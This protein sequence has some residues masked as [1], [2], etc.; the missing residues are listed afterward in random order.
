[1]NR[2]CAQEEQEGEGSSVERKRKRNGALTEAPP[3]HPEAENGEAAGG[4]VGKGTG[5][6]KATTGAGQ[7]KKVRFFFFR[8]V[9][10]KQI[11]CQK[12]AKKVFFVALC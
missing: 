2:H 10:Q 4:I 8:L 9:L 3:P 1:M 6:A 12:S 11:L 7:V 5:A